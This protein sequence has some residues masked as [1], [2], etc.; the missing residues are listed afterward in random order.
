MSKKLQ[1]ALV[2]VVAGGV[3]AAAFAQN[4]PAEA[5]A[6]PAAVKA[7]AAP[8]AF[9]IGRGLAIFGSCVGAG[10]AAI[11]GALGIGRIGGSMLESVARQPEASSA[12]FAPMII[13]AAMVEGGMLFAIV[14]AL[15][16]VLAK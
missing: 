5:A 4:A 12:L 9:T 3:T 16:G 8:A 15:L 13:T 14:L 1:M 11:G 2:L 10:I 6:T 7:E